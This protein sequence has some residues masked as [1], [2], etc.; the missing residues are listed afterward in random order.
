MTE[1]EPS[2]EDAKPAAMT[3]FAT[4]MLRGIAATAVF[5]FV[6]WLAARAGWGLVPI[7]LI[8]YL[9]WAIALGLIFWL[10]R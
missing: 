7:L 8:S 10:A 2:A 3:D 5:V 1:H 4:S 6:T 9:A